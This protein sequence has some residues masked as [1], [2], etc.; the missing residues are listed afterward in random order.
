MRRNPW[1][2]IG[3][4]AAAVIV[5]AVL[6]GTFRLLE[7]HGAFTE[8]KPG[9]AGTCRSVNGVVGPEDIAIDAQDK[10]AFVS[11]TNR[12]ARSAGKPSPGDGLYAYNYLQ[13][14]A[15]LVK[16]VGTPSDFHPHG[17]SLY[18]APDGSL[19]LMAINHRL[20][21]T[22]SVDIFAVGFLGID[23]TGD[24]G[25]IGADLVRLKEVGSIGSGLLTSPNDL[26]AVDQDRF[27]VVN[28]HTSKTQLGRW[29]DDN[30]VLPRT[31]ILYFDGISFKIAADG[32]N[33]P[34]GAALSKD[35]RYLYVPESYA[36]TLLTFERNIFSGQLKQ[37]N[38]LPIASNLDNADVAS[39]GSIWI[40]SHPDAFAMDTYRNDQSKP[41]PSEVFQVSV[42]NGVPQSAAL[43]Y[44]NMGE[45]IGASSV[46]AVSDGHLLIGSPF[47]SKILNCMLP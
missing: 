5:V 17:I 6:T 27:Y 35:G 7:S 34:N 44:A 41:A 14:G 45:Q 4:T 9:F 18:R 3:A 22:N 13:P 1:Y 29:L 15:K 31:N 38:A 39:D 12:P 21:G 37:V 19:T 40:G 30:L 47:D 8:V 42:H 43:V 28:D 25:P 46:G 2:R 23:V 32:L 10:I 33:F 24:K 26:A 20:D 36:R 11:A 16:L